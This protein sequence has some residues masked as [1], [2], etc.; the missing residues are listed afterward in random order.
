MAVCT[1]LLAF[2]SQA[3]AQKTIPDTIE[4]RTAA[5]VAC[6]GKQGVGT[7]NGYA[8]RIAGK[9]AGYLYNQ[10]QNFR[11]GRRQS[12][13]MTY[14]VS[15][16]SDAY[17]MEIAHYFSGLH[18]PYPQP[19]RATLSAAQTERARALVMSGDPARNVP[20]CVA[21]HGKNLTGYAP[22]IPALIGLP[23]DYLNAQFGNWVNRTRHAVEP[24]CMAQIASRLHPD[25]INAIS[26]W[27]AAQPVPENSA[28]VTA[29][30]E[31]LPLDCGSAQ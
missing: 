4:Q 10:L 8:P 30:P 1:M 29:L 31:R 5:C 20:A 18:L 13:A 12:Q 27:L 24:D 2:C 14:M 16:L 17:L 6:H 11:E 7:G 15:H 26:A 9:P 19:Q 3:L 25:E 23:H 28:A 22:A 21:C